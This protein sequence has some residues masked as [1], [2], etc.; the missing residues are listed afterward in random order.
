MAEAEAADHPVTAPTCSPL[1]V[2]EEATTL[3]WEAQRNHPRTVL[4]HGDTSQANVLRPPTGYA[5]IDWEGARADVPWWE[6]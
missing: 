6:A 3:V 1:P 4:V 2:I 5:L